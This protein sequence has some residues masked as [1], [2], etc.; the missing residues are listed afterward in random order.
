[1]PFPRYRL[2]FL[3][4]GKRVPLRKRRRLLATLTNVV[5]NLFIIHVPKAYYAK[6]RVFTAFYDFFFRYILTHSH[7]L[8]AP[9]IW[10]GHGTLLNR[11]LSKF[12]NS[13]DVCLPQILIYFLQ[14]L[15]RFSPISHFIRHSSQTTQWTLVLSGSSSHALEQSND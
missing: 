1:M 10:G 9:C 14:E 13:T 12:S 8:Q 6:L 2:S 3:V 4:P 5:L 11:N 15:K 7:H